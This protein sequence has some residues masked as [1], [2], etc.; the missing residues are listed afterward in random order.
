MPMLKHLFVLTLLLVASPVL[1]Q[2]LPIRP[3]PQLTPGAVLTTDPATICVPGYAKTVRHTSGKLKA[4]VYRAYRIDKNAGHFEVD[5][6][7]SLELGGADVAANLWP[8][9]YD[10]MP[11]NAHLKD[12]LEHRLNALVCTRKLSLEEA[13]RAIAEDWIAAYQRFVSPEPST[14]SA[15][16]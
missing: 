8:E 1:G 7:I 13:Q 12:R 10:T 14:L 2:E 16:P 6:L 11:W 3:D 9:S 15:R 4:Q 5:H